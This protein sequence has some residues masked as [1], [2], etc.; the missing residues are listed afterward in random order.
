MLQE[1]ASSPALI[2]AVQA[3]LQNSAASATLVHH[4]EMAP[5][6]RA[7]RRLVGEDT[8]LHPDCGFRFVRRLMYSQK[9]VVPRWRPTTAPAAA[10]WVRLNQPAIV[11]VDCLS[12]ELTLRLQSAP[13]RG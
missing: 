11:T 13:P 12:A 1:V 5:Y 10:S 9:G 8:W 7:L 3:L 6:I 2:D 4:P